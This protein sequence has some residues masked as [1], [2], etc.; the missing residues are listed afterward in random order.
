M[1]YFGLER[2]KQA[3]EHL[4]AFNSA[5]TIVPLVLAANGVNPRELVNIDDQAKPGT[6]RFLD[7]FFSGSVIG[8][9]VFDNGR[10]VLR[11]K[12]S[13]LKGSAASEADLVVHQKANLW[14]STYSSRGYRE[15]RSRGE[16]AGEG[17]EFKVNTAFV[18]KWNVELPA[19][20]HFEEMLVW[21][22]AFSGF[23]DSVDSWQDLL[24]DYHTRVL[25]G[26]SFDPCFQSR[27]HVKNGLPWPALLNFRP[28]NEEFVTALLPSFIAPPLLATPGE[29]S[30]DIVTVFKEKACDS[31]VH[32]TEPLVL[33]FAASLLTKQFLILTGL[34]GSGKT[35]MA[36]AFAH[37]LTPDPGWVDAAD[38]D[39]GKMPNSQLV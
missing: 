14:G 25:G 13:D 36:Q 21:L 17:S 5:W 18:P 10:S 19:T 4:G 27:F 33:R 22:Y 24:A 16:L 9:P 6:T 26:A 29:F 34:A 30:K 20:F 12:F 1:K 31:G 8:L 3:T 7:R 23:P 32:V 39:K 15:M 28:S 2:V 38:P 37:W 11:P 35:K